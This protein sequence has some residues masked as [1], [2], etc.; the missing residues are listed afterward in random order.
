MLERWMD[1]EEDETLLKRWQTPEETP[2]EIPPGIPRSAVRPDELR[3]QLGSMPQ[4]TGP[5]IAPPIPQP[6]IPQD[7]FVSRMSDS[8]SSDYAP[9]SGIPQAGASTLG[10]A[11]QAIMGV[12]IVQTL[13]SGLS[14]MYA[15]I[16]RIPADIYDVFALPQ[17]ALASA[18]G[19]DA[20]RA[21]SPEWLQ[22]NPVAK[23]YDKASE[24]SNYVNERWGKQGIGF[25]QLV[26]KGDI[27]EIVVFR[28]PGSYERP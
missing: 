1:K 21:Q 23:Y 5:V 6:G 14:N 22:N 16:A 18:T 27:G 20:I 9:P 8:G 15:N 12:P 2:P 13:N 4:S 26:D 3:A 17:N 19:W 28:P 11:E 24:S 7:P 25:E 10:K